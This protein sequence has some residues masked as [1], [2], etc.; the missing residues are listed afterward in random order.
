MVD[1][2]AVQMVEPKD[3]KK[4]DLMAARMDRMRAALTVASKVF[5]R[6]DSKVA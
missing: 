6:A 5:Q 4:V 3:N 2:M 1:S